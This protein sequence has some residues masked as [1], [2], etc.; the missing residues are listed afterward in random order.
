M[1]G[2]PMREIVINADYGG[3]WLSHKAVMRYAEL[4]KLDL[5]Y[6]I[7]NSEL[8]SDDAADAMLV[9][10][11]L[12]KRSAKLFND[13]YF[14]P[15]DIKRDDPLLLQVVKELGS[16]ASSRFS[17]LKVVRIPADVKWQIEEYDGLEWVAEAHRTWH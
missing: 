10:Y 9:H 1:K 17:K 2:K 8:S 11:Y 12:N 5:R 7:D 14:N 13:D 4:A 16:K 6:E 15:R 3:F